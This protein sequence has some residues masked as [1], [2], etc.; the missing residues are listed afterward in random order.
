LIKT[1]VYQKIGKI[2][3]AIDAY[4]KVLD[5]N[6]EEIAAHKYLGLLYENKGMNIEAESEIAIYKRL[7]SIEQQPNTNEQK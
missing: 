6:V 1:L 3:E 7:K 4:K 2:D 5:I